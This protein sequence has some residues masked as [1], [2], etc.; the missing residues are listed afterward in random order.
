MGAIT[1][2]GGGASL[3]WGGDNVVQCERD[4]SIN[5]LGG[6]HQVSSQGMGSPKRRVINE[7]VEAVGCG[8]VS[9]R[10]WHSNGVEG[11]G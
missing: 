10:R 7:A 8:G 9:M 3:G 11:G 1:A 4:L 5:V 6:A 2:L